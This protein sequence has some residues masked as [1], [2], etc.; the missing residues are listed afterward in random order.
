MCLFIHSS[1]QSQ[2]HFDRSFCS[3]VVFLCFFSLLTFP[4]C[5]SVKP[6][7][8]DDLLSTSSELVAFTADCLSIDRLHV[9]R[10]VVLFMHVVVLIGSLLICLSGKNEDVVVLE[11][12]DA[13]VVFFK[14]R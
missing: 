10:C 7:G 2:G 14:D 8:I 6:R 12:E 1:Q 5:V 9:H 3:S 13:I 11:L 4:W